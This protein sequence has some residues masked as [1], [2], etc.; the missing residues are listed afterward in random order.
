[1]S[2]SITGPMNPYNAV[3]YPS[4]AKEQTHPDRLATIAALHGLEAAPVERCRVLELGCGTG[5]NLIPMAY[6]LP[7]SEFT[8]IDAAAGPVDAGA[9]RIAELGLRNTR[10]LAADIT[11]IGPAF[12]E[13]DYIVAHGVYSWVPEPVR[14]KL[15]AVCAANLAPHGVAYVSYNALPGFHLR[16]MVRDILL[17][18]VAAV[19]DPDE[20]VRQAVA[21][22]GLVAGAQPQGELRKE[23]EGVFERAG[24]VLYHDD[25]AEVNHP[26]Y[27]HEFVRHA[28]AHGLQF[29]SEATVVAGEGLLPESARA[30]LQPLEADVLRREQYLDFLR[31]RR[32]RQTL[33][34]R[35]GLAL[36]RPTRPE[37]LRSLWAA[38]KAVASNTPDGPT[39]AVEFR[40]EKGAAA[41][42]VHPLAIAA[43]ACLGSAWPRRLA[44]PDLLREARAATATAAPADQ[45]AAALAD[46]LWHTA[47]CG[48][49][50]LHA[51]PGRFAPQPGERPEASATARLELRDG[52]TAATL[53]HGVVEIEDEI[54]RRLVRLLDGSRDRAALA[55]ELQVP[56]SALEGKLLHLARLPLLVA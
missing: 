15:L 5:A 11:D 33:L 21:I 39:G 28:A 10:L 6:T 1:M 19:E 26:V 2:V 31:L 9:G 3:R 41:K 16:R 14:E 49:V 54:G 55:A 56:L 8:G 12:G 52:P 4:K 40:G 45:D 22:A 42:T 27:F 24:P 37:R 48:L 51:C 38:S 35:E 18:H 46:I 47:R 20:R 23:F 34:C 43:L 50:E 13:F 25:L 7:D 32:F 29:L 30:V 17:Y 36:D 53:D 44:F